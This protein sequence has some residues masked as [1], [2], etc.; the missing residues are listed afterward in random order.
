[1]RWKAHFFLSDNNQQQENFNTYGFKSRK[2]PPHITL[3]DEFEKDLYD[4][5]PSLKYRKINNDFQ[6]N[7]KKDISEI[8]S[9][10]NMF[11][12]ADKTNN[13]YEINREDHEKLITANI[14]KTYQKA[15]KKLEIAIN[16]EAK[17]VANT[18]KLAERI[19]HLPKAECFI[20]LKDHKEN[21]CNKPTCRLINPT[22]NELGKISKQM[23]E[24][25]NQRLLK[26]LQVNQWKNTNDV[27]N[28]FNHIE[29]KMNA[30]LYNLI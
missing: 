8:I 14:T 25:I 26:E 21:F 30:P 13:L 1:M 16:M 22:K 9:S 10:K 17:N 12:F 11:I 15:P 6:K 19:D 27:I 3:L 2:Y 18:Y 24:R 7:L 4:I 5:V 28:W 20:T 23:I 29:K